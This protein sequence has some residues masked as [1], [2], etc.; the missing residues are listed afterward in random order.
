MKEKQDILDAWITVEQ[1]GEGNIDLKKGDNVKYKKLPTECKNW[2]TFF[3]NKIEEYKEYNKHSYKNFKNIGFTIFFDVF[4]FEKLINELFIKFHLFEEYREETKTKKFTYCV[5][6]IVDEDSFKLVGTSL[7]YTMSGYIHRNKEFPEDIYEEEQ[8]LSK[9]L[10]EFFE[11]DFEKGMLQIIEKEA[12]W[13]TKNYYE[14]CADV[15]E[16]D[17]FFHSFYID[18]LILAKNSMSDNLNRYLFGFL[19][20]KINL[21]S[22]KDSQ[23]FNK[24]E[25]IKIL[26]P[27]NYPLGRFPSNPKYALS[28]MQQIAVNIALNDNNDIRGVNGPPGTGKTTLLKD[29]FAELI[30]QQAFDICNLKNKHLEE[31]EIYY[32]NGK[33][34]KLSEC[35][36]DKNILVASSNNGAV[37]N[38]VNELPLQKGI[39]AQ[40]LDELLISDYFSDISNEESKN[41]NWGTFSLEGGR[42]ANI[43]KIIEVLKKMSDELFAD[44]YVSNPGV[45]DDYMKQ[46]N[47]VYSMREYAQNIADKNK[48]YFILQDKLKLKKETFHKELVIKEAENEK[49]FKQINAEISELILSIAKCEDNIKSLDDEL[50]DSDEK[51]EELKSRSNLI[52]KQQ[53]FG[54]WF[55]KIIRH[56]SVKAH[57]DK[58]S[59][60][61]ELRKKAFEE[62]SDLK[63]NYKKEQEKLLV[64]KTKHDNCINDKESTNKDFVSWK[65]KHIDDIDKLQCNLESLE[66]EIASSGIKMLNFE[67][68][69]SD[70]QQD[71]PWF[72][73]DYR[74][75]QSKLFIAAMAVRKQFLYENRKSLKASYNIWKNITDYAIPAKEHLI[76][77]SW[78]WINF[79]I[80]IVSTTFA[81]F[82]RMFKHMKNE[83]IAN[84]FI[85]EAGQATP[86]SAVGAILRSRRVMAVGDPAQ[87]T[88]V[89]SLSKAVMGLITSRYA[90]F[91]KI[92]NVVNGYSSV[93]TLIDEASQFGYKKRNGEWIG[94]PLW[95]HRRCL[96]PMFN[97][98]NV[99]SYDCQ[100]VLP[101]NMLQPGKGFW[102]DIS[103]KSENKF[104]KEQAEWLKNKIKE[105]MDNKEIHPSIYVI[106]PFKNVVD[107]LRKHLGKI[108]FSKMNV[109]TVHTFQGKEADIVY[110]VLGASWEETGA[111]SWAVSEA[112]LMNVSATRAKKE[113]Y[114]IGDKA[115]YRSLKSEVINQTLNILENHQKVS[116]S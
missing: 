68:S 34:A 12:K 41:E 42:R 85:D 103:G 78:S 69:Y 10:A 80:P 1:F 3:K 14:I 61:V 64:L 37:Q 63:K 62:R 59:D 54:F 83:S 95:V 112:N 26:Q 28:L 72:G 113:F 87:I 27:K 20:K 36:A 2:T 52:N 96:N 30:V 91:K 33:I 84:L 81:S 46:Y 22:N 11:Y 79:A 93:Q 21:D 44:N 5:S 90:S 8:Q 47:Y 108:G 40:F 115:L 66:K 74:I 92:E 25:I 60:V 76:A 58:L 105:E 110:L 73:E 97:I 31:T 116:N 50:V 77:W 71:N 65:Q 32:K 99:I 45:Y 107:Q 35:I 55:L 101:N 48:N 13:S 70:L 51:L 106:S 114:I 82:N 102:I 17:A 38:I 94:I 16:R 18:D 67:Q 75:A 29:I 6:F 88:P 109:G 100:M 57:L 56:E 15:T 24:E 23:L 7:F 98:S 9:Q 53:P 43:Q 4:N 111:A 19:G 86:Q 39:D 49:Y 89:L 104:V